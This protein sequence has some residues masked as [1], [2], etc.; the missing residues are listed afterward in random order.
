LNFGKT[1]FINDKFNEIAVIDI[2]VERYKQKCA[3]NSKKD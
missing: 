2:F 1:A 3:K